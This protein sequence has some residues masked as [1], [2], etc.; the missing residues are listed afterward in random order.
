MAPKYNNPRCLSTRVESKLR[1][2]IPFTTLKQNLS[3]DP[4]L[5]QMRC[6][7]KLQTRFFRTCLVNYNTGLKNSKIQWCPLKASRNSAEQEDVKLLDVEPAKVRNA[8][9]L[10]DSANSPRM[11]LLMSPGSTTSMAKTCR[12]IATERLKGRIRRSRM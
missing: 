7:H 3:A 9:L 11:H 4:T 8:P 12:L 1:S 6:I 5:L 10:A 2:F